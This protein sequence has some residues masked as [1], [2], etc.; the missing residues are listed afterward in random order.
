MSTQSPTQADPISTLLAMTD[1]LTPYAIRAAVSLDLPRL[2]AEGVR[3]PTALAEHCGADP[4]ALA[5]LA[6]YLARKGIFL[7]AEEGLSLTPVGQ[8]VLFEQS[9]IMLSTGGAADHLHRAW[10]GLT[11]A[12][13]TGTSGYE[14]LFGHDFWSTLSGDPALSASFDRYM[15][16]W[17]ERWIPAAVAA[18]DWRADGHIVDVGGGAGQLVGALLRANPTLEGS[19]VDLPAAAERAR[20][21][22]ADAG[23]ASRAQVFEASFFD[24][25]PRHGDLYI[26]AQ[27]LHD[28]PDEAAL[29]ILRRCAA[30]AG[31]EGKVLIVER[32]MGQPP[33]ADQLASDLFMLVLFGA[34][35]RTLAEF[36]DLASGAGLA[37][38]GTHDIGFGLFA[39]ELRPSARSAET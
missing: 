24:E 5:S 10:P 4:R 3:T 14:A 25:L 30:A 9:R 1:L 6:A 39:I 11:H 27:V 38:A 2:V 15:E 36:G 12:V 19:V 20:K 37:V 29:A 7:E 31:P 8:L 16:H 23:L 28:W 17:G 18:R 22:F 21:A 13:R 32:V 33:T 35:E 34:K 26:L